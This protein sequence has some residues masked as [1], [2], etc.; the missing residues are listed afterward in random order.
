MKKI[1]LG[2]TGSL[3]LA[4]TAQAELIDNSKTHTGADSKVI[5]PQTRQASWRQPPEIHINERRLPYCDCNDK[6]QLL[7]NCREQKLTTSVAMIIDEQGEVTSVSVLKSSGIDRVDRS[8]VRGVKRASF[9]P[10]MVN[11]VPTAGQV[12]VPIQNIYK[13]RIPASC[14]ALQESL[15]TR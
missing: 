8:V 10:F 7:A 4:M 3:L 15:R 6:G 12:Q 11:D 13:P 9:Y 2:L 1:L 5:A 14:Y